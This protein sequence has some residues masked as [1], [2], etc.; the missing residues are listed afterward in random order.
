MDEATRGDDAT[1]NDVESSQT[2]FAR[3]FDKLVSHYFN[4]QAALARTLGVADQTVGAWRKPEAQGGHAPDSLRRATEIAQA[5]ENQIAKAGD[6]FDR[7]EFMALWAATNKDRRQR[8]G[9]KPPKQPPQSDSSPKPDSAHPVEDPDIGA[10]SPDMDDLQP[11]STGGREASASPSVGVPPALEPSPHRRRRG[12]LIPMLVLVAVVASLIY[13]A[14]SWA[15]NRQSRTA[16][17]SPSSQTGATSPIS[18]VKVLYRTD[19]DTAKGAHV[20]ELPPGGSVDQQFRAVTPKIVRLAAVIGSSDFADR[21]E[22]GRVRFELLDCTAVPVT[23]DVDAFNNVDTVVTLDP[24]VPLN[25]GQMC[26]LR[27][28]NLEQART[29]GLY[30]NRNPNPE[31]QTV[32]HGAVDPP[33]ASAPHEHDLSGQVLGQGP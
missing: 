5:L 30:F 23:H 29:L 3:H 17:P 11:F 32:L 28:T 21:A 15:S 22:I 7:E 33:G 2:R 26:T 14:I 12:L 31:N 20:H 4:S 9:V 25:Q 1:P 13:I 8:Q 6:Q 18:Q 24:P 10:N 16:F 19:A 27:V